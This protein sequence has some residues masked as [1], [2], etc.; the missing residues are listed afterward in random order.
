MLLGA[1]RSALSAKL[2]EQKLTIVDGW[3][4]DTHK[5]KTLRNALDKLNAEKTALLVAYGDNKNLE[6][7]SRNMEGVKLSASNVLQPYDVLRHDRVV[8]SKDAAAR[9]IRTLDPE[10]PS[11]EAPHVESIAPAP[12]AAAKPA[13][14]GKPAAKKPVAAKKPAAKKGKG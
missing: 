3:S 11:V 4:L 14:A 1:L 13:T 7:A 6:L 8:V 5:T 2:A 9:L 12:K 10:H